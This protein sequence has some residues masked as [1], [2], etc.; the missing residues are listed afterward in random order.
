MITIIIILFLMAIYV[1][2]SIQWL[3]EKNRTIEYLQA[4]A[5]FYETAWERINPAPHLHLQKEDRWYHKP[6]CEKC[7]KKAGYFWNLSCTDEQ[8]DIYQNICKHY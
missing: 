1:V 4:K 2:L 8:V 5:S 3:Q 7:W 6:F